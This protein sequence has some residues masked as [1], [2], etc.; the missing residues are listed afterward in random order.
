MSAS[1]SSGNPDETP[2]PA[3]H[4]GH[5]AV[6]VPGQPAEPGGEA[7]G[8]GDVPGYR[9]PG[10]GQDPG[11][12]APPGGQDAGYGQDPGG[13]APPSGQDAGYGQRSGGYAGYGYPGY[14]QG[15]G[16][17]YGPGLPPPAGA[18]PAGW[19]AIAPAPGGVPLRPMSVGDILSGAFTLIRKNPAATLGVSAI[20]FTVYGVCSVLL[21]NSVLHAV[22]LPALNH[23]GPLTQAEV[24]AEYSAVGRILAAEGGLV[25]LALLFQVIVTGVLTGALG[26]GLLGRVV[27]FGD[28]WHGARLPAVLLVVV[29]PAVIVLG[30][31]A[32][33]AAIV[34]GA[35]AAHATG[36]AILV[37]VAGFLAAIP[38]AIWLSVRWSIAVPA[39]VLERLGPVAA[40][41]RSW[42]LVRGSFWRVLG[43]TLLAALVVG[44]AQAV[45]G[46]PFALAGLLG[47]RGGP[48]AFGIPVGHSLA[49]TIIIAIGSIISN[50]VTRPIGAG[51]TVLLYTDLRMRKEGLDLTL[52]RAAQD[53][54]MTGE[55]FA[56][57]WRPPGPRPTAG[58]VPSSAAPPS[59]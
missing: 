59:W 6:P 51:V 34:V 43:I 42:H 4:P 18:G 13:Y 54:P 39:V 10:Y 44:V 53:R 40:M 56:T 50:A 49:A 58:G 36:V 28:A 8:A 2:R 7:P 27:S 17:G 47:S 48:P 23:T 31:I 30:M 25:V 11:G 33:P 19:G 52:Q 14:R 45:L 22:S 16:Y 35:L 29:Y 24:N 32:V 57:I 9:H 38:V 37:G 46:T 5:S 1:S 12:Y 41:R 26:R 55:E 20:V 3:G 21:T 15:S